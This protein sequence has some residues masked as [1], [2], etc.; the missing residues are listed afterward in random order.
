VQSTSTASAAGLLAKVLIP[1]EDKLLAI[2]RNQRVEFTQVCSAK[3]ARLR[4]FQ[5]IEPKLGVAFRLFH[6]DMPRLPPFSAEKEESIGADS[7]NLWHGG[8][9]GG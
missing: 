9:R 4:E 7:E 5:G 2:L 1:S 3:A 6:M 8:M